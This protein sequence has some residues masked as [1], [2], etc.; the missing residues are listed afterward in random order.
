MTPQL[1][2]FLAYIAGIVM[3]IQIGLNAI[4]ARQAG[5]PMWASAISFVVGGVA[6]FAFYFASRQ[7]W[8]SAQ[9]VASIPFWAWAGGLLGAFYVTMTIV[10]APQI[11]AALFVALAIGGQMTA[12]LLLDH[13][14][15]LGF[16][17]HSINWLRVL[18]AAMV[19]GGVVL[20][21]RF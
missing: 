2:I 12:A 9:A 19:V 15:G 11:G 6:L 1:S 5:S 16:P 18:G 8:P 10:V 17:Q 21:R 20:I 13:Y 7:G 4:V 14:G 3:P